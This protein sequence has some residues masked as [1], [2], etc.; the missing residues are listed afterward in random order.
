MAYTN[1]LVGSVTVSL[2]YAAAF[3]GAF[4]SSKLLFECAVSVKRAHHSVYTTHAL[5]QN[6]VLYKRSS[7]I[8][9]LSMTVL[10]STAFLVLGVLW[11]DN[12]SCIQTLADDYSVMTTVS[13][14][15]SFYATHVWFSAALAITAI[16][17]TSFKRGGFG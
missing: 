11:Y 7:F 6:N 8:G 16:G 10:F 9:R 4:Y 13:V 2:V 12:Y 17:Y 14:S 15:N 3:C 5:P 1:G